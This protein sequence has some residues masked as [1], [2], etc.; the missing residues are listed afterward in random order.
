MK[1]LGIVGSPRRGGNTDALVEQVLA[2]ARAQRAETE[3]LYL[4]ELEIRPC[5]ACFSRTETGECVVRDDFQRVVEKL[6]GADGIVLGSP[7]YVGT[8]TAQMKAFIDRA[9]CTLV[10]MVRTPEEI[11]FVSRLGSGRKGVVVAV[12]DLTPMRILRQCAWVM[13]LSFHDLGVELVDRVLATR[14]SDVGD[15]QRRPRLLER[16]F[17]AG[18][19]LALAIST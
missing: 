6:K 15:A 13:E 4:D 5:R 19:K 10:E 2:G 8:V 1:V 9:N 16:A 7:M 3:K 14:L 18:E 12:C 17:Q 11:R